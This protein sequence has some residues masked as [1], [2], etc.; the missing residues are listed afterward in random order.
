MIKAIRYSLINTKR[1]SVPVIIFRR[2]V[3]LCALLLIQLFVFAQKKSAK[4]DLDKAKQMQA[5]GLKQM[6]EQ[7]KELEKTDPKN[8]K[9]IR[10][11]M[12]KEM[13]GESEDE[14]NSG[15]ATKASVKQ[16]AKLNT[17]PS[18]IL[19]KAEL[20]EWS[21][22][23]FASLL[24]KL[25]AQEKARFNTAL[26]QCGDNAKNLEDAA[27]LNWIKKSP[28][29]ALLY[30]MKATIINPD[31]AMLWSNLAALLN[32][33]GNEH[34]AVAPLRY[35]QKSFP[36]NSIVLNNLGQAY[37]G[38]GDLTTAKRYFDSCLKYNP[39]HPEANHSMGLI[40]RFMGNTAKSN[41]HFERETRVCVKKPVV[42]ELQKNKSEDEL[43]EIVKSKFL[44]PK[45]YLTLLGLNNFVVPKLP[46]SVDESN[47]LY[48]AHLDFQKNVQ[49]E[50]KKW[51][52]LDANLAMNPPPQSAQRSLYSYLLETV[53]LPHLDKEKDKRIIRWMQQEDVSNI[54][55]PT[56]GS[57]ASR[58]GQL[59]SKKYSEDVMKIYAAHRY[60]DSV[61][62]KKR[63]AE[64]SANPRNS[65]A[66]SHKWAQIRIDVAIKYCQ[67]EIELADAFLRENAGSQPIGFEERTNTII[68]L[69][70][71]AMSYTE[72]APNDVNVALQAHNLIAVYLTYLDAYSASTV[73]ASTKANGYKGFALNIN[74]DMNE[75][76]AQ[77]YELAQTT[78]VDAECSF[79]IVVPLVVAKL[80][81][82]CQKVEVEGGEIL[83]VNVE[84]EFRSGNTTLAIGPG[85]G[86]DLPYI[87]VG[88]KNQ[89]FVTF[90]RN[91]N[92]SDAGL[93]GEVGVELSGYL[94]S[95]GA[96][97][98]NLGLG[99]TLEAKAGYEFSINSGA[100]AKTEIAGKETPIVF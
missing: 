37:L 15:L 48:Q 73:I 99:P 47:Q 94:Q 32:L 33:T 19:S 89:A 4:T 92:Y 28:K 36:K 8:A 100:S 5:E 82:D 23:S 27:L 83:I 6:E 77:K 45:N 29:G 51:G 69:L 87:S 46:A 30:A 35:L 85:A 44:K 52:T 75:L 62:D 39:Y 60:E 90:D 25:S 3:L 11:M 71:E 65:L 43:Y 16:V 57:I 63:L 86:V 64:E 12:E 14:E 97:I 80:S 10:D 72:L 84:H 53:L 68:E 40:Y 54:T 42:E 38:L 21:K 78:F 74:C 91:G 31:D 93:K 7:L 20:V 81:F 66:I 98:E 88:A 9:M 67:Q 24:G 95:V 59:R 56:P 2:S 34:K 1:I 22:R 76:Q 79:K 49:D 96:E 18:Q 26:A 17:I 61:N 13:S 55:F 50:I 41:Y 70:N 58:A